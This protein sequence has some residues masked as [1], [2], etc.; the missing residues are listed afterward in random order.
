MYVT[1]TSKMFV[2]VLKACLVSSDLCIY[3]SFWQ[4]PLNR[5]AALSSQSYLDLVR[6]DQKMHPV[7]K[8]TRSAPC[9]P[10]MAPSK[11]ESMLIGLDQK[12]VGQNEST[13]NAGAVRSANNHLVCDPDD[14]ELEY[15]M[16]LTDDRVVLNNKASIHLMYVLEMFHSRS[17][18]THPHS[19][20]IC[21]FSVC[22]CCG[23]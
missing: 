22:C 3:F 23:A 9:T 18:P 6:H 19:W 12:Q 1:L 13:M 20:S 2:V 4:R 14:H 8:G 17:K 15:G 21:S 16:P 11:V 5:K 10:V 7:V